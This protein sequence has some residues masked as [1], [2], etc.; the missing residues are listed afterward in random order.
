[1][2]LL[3]K[4]CAYAAVVTSLAG[5]NLRQQH[6]AP[7]LNYP[8]SERE[9][10]EP[11]LLL[12]RDSYAENADQQKSSNAMEKSKNAFVIP[13]QTLDQTEINALLEDKSAF[14]VFMQ[15]PRYQDGKKVSFVFKKGSVKKNVTRIAALFEVDN[16]EWDLGYDYNLPQT[17]SV[18][19]SSKEELLSLL[20]EPFP[21]EAKIET[22]NDSKVLI[23][24]AVGEIDKDFRFTVYKGSF[25]ENFVRLA[26][27][28]EW[29]GR[30]AF[31]YDFN[32]PETYVVRGTSYQNILD[33]LIT[34]YSLPVKKSIED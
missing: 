19:A 21:L 5:C 3:F 9:A 14:Y 18:I 1:M 4:Y 32:I 15:N 7:P 28:G 25:K 12:E 34:K 29:D 11:T 24:G 6:S 31:D 17:S 20:L 26:D 33:K 22:K 16:I 27:K 2:P 8:V 23:V 13:G 10:W 30:W